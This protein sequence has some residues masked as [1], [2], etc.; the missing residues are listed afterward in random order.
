MLTIKVIYSHRSITRVFEA[1]SYMYD[2][3]DNRIDGT[4]SS[5]GGFSIYLGPDSASTVYVMNSSGTTVD[6][7]R[8]LEKV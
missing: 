1:K 2:A 8:Y 5:G 6:T 7:L 4:D 3:T